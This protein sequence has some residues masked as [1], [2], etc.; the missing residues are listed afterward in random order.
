MT[1]FAIVPGVSPHLPK[2]VAIGDV[3]APAAPTNAAE[4]DLDTQLIHE[5]ALK[6]AAAVPQL[7][8]EWAA[9]QLHLPQQLLGDVLEQLRVEHL[10]DVL[11]QAGPFG[12][13]YAITQRGRDAAARLLEISGYIG[14]APVSL[15]AYTAMIEWQLAQLPQRTVE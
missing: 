10:L 5:L 1:N 12:Y 8:T 7:N 9:R 3:P 13:R 6:T 2:M 15:A 14:P 11:G 4:T